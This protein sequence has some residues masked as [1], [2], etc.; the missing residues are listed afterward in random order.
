[1]PAS[2]LKKHSFFRFRLKTYYNYCY[3]Y[4]RVGTHLVSSSFDDGG[5][6]GG[7]FGVM[8]DQSAAAG[9]TDFITSLNSTQPD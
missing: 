8:S 3:Y 7:V 1:M 5:R 6:V 2:F 4:Y 9:P